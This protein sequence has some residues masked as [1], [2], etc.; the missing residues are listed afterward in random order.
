M[1]GNMGSVDRWIRG[2][3]GAAIVI[4]GFAAGSLWGALGVILLVT[5]FVGVCPAYFPFGFRTGPR[6]G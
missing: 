5:A 6:R 2:V 4:W 1:R 3:L